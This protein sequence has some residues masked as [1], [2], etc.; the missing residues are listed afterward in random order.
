MIAGHT[1]TLRDVDPLPPAITIDRRVGT[2]AECHTA[3]HIPDQLRVCLSVPLGD[4]RAKVPIDELEKTPGRM[5]PSL[6]PL[7][8]GDSPPCTLA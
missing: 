6:V 5:T 1:R 2:T 8:A 3:L 7:P 4:I